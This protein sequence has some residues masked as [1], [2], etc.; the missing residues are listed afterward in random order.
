MRA[1]REHHWEIFGFDD[2]EDGI[3]GEGR[4]LWEGLGSWGGESCER[5]V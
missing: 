1:F 5:D 2:D 3:K 4:V